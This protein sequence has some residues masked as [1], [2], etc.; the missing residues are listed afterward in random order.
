MYGEC[1]L[2]PRLLR[3]VRM[4]SHHWT[5]VSGLH[6][7]LQS[8]YECWYPVTYCDTFVHSFSVSYSVAYEAAIYSAIVL[9]YENPF[10]QPNHLH[11]SAYYFPSTFCYPHIVA[12]SW[13]N[14]A[15]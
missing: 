7:V 14:E 1:V 2:Q 8:I 9:A 5:R 12:I 13:T 10:Q 6:Q 4:G 11:F 15:A 3:S